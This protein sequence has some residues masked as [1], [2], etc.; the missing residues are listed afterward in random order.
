MKKYVL[1]GVAFILLFAY[2]APAQTGPWNSPLMMAR[3]I[4]GQN[5]GTPTIFQDSSGVPSA[6]RWKSDTLACVFQWFRQPIGSAS[7]DRVAVKFS[8]NNGQSWTSPT[9]IVV[10]GIPGNYQRPFDPT[11]AV[12]SRDSLRIYFSSSVGMAQQGLDALINTY[13]AV[14]IDG[15]HYTFEANP[16]V[17]HP[18]NRVIDPAVIYFAGRWHY[19]S[20]VGAPQ[21]GAYHYTSLDGV[22]FS[23]QV[24]YGSDNTHNWT[25]NFLVQSNSE[26]RFYGSGPRLWFSSSPDGFLW[27]G[28]VNTNL[29]GGDPTVVTLGTSSY[30]IVYVGPP[31]ATAIERD[32]NSVP[33]DFALHP[34]YPNPFNPAT[35]INYQLPA[36]SRV[37]L[38]V[39]NLLGQEITTIVD[40]E[41]ISGY[42][43][44]Q[45]NGS[46]FASGAYV[47]R[48]IRSAPGG[49][50]AS[51]SRVMILTR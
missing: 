6:V 34:N 28:T 35:V 14:S 10:D 33:F 47:Y 37:S 9:P 40:G 49:I 31:Y 20:P 48:L 44:E 42:H 32:E 27:N 29:V 13:S 12:I 1:T 45:W 22:N 46:G 25:G 23:P 3:S 38:K 30:L 4:D 39:Y 36:T 8:Y 17:D 15:I 18:T 50:S 11:L 26:L 16:R 2:K 19:C 7:W 51:A 43:Q 21:D 41:Q 24:N 5:F